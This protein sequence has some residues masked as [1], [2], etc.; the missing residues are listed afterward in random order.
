MGYICTGLYVYML[1]RVY[2]YIWYMYVCM[3][4]CVKNAHALHLVMLCLA[5]PIGAVGVLWES[6]L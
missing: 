5:S 3:C 1:N 6:V 2:I 4:H